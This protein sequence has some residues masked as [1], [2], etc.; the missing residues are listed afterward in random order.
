[1]DEKQLEIIRNFE[2]KIEPHKFGIISTVKFLLTQHFPDTV[3]RKIEIFEKK[4]N[5]LLTLHSQE[6]ST[7]LSRYYRLLSTFKPALNTILES[8]QLFDMICDVVVDSANR[9][10]DRIR[11]QINDKGYTP[12]SKK[13]PLPGSSDSFQLFYYCV[14]CHQIIEIPPEIQVDL[15]NSEEKHE[16]PHHCGKPMSIKIRRLK[17]HT[18]QKE[19]PLKPIT[20][21][22]AELLMNH[23][24]SEESGAEYL[25]IVSVGIDIGSSTS[26]LVFSRLTLKRE[27]S[28]FNLTKRFNIIDRELIY[29]GRI[30]FTPL[31]DRNT[32]DIDAIEKFCKEE[33]Q[34]AGITEEMVDTGGSDC[35]WRNC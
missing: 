19:A 18:I 3:D 31:I 33:Y 5:S 9:V 23:I 27:T 4:W 1:M 2:I 29:E 16:L 17:P 20:I 22:P 7:D 11:S 12:K 28:F 30:I 21:Y 34:R 10:L 6:D 14:V 13:I 8:G 24:N 15:L 35:N 26:H 32:I 25:K